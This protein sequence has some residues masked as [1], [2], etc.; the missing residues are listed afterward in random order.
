MVRQAAPI[1]IDSRSAR[2]YSP[3]RY[4]TG[5]LMSTAT[6]RPL[7]FQLWFHMLVAMAVGIVL[8]Y[9]DPGAGKAMKPLGDGFI[10]L[11]E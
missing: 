6:R 7:Y 4:A 10:K 11:I 2:H 8:G 5:H 9:V 1:S 3:R